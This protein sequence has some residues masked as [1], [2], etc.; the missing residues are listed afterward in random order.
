MP[1]LTT[2]WIPLGLLQ[3]RSN[4]I[5]CSLYKYNVKELL[6]EKGLLLVLEAR[7]RP[8][9]LRKFP[10]PPPL[11]LDGHFD[12]VEEV[13]CEVQEDEGC[14]FHELEVDHVGYSALRHL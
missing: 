14:S 11:L 13:L 3:V 9:V 5:G 6:A 10:L 1:I 4:V 2:R 12:E 7:G 8:P